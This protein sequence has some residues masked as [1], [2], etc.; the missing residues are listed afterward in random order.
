M[1]TRIQAFL[2]PRHTPD[3]LPY[4]AH[5]PL[6]VSILS[7]ILY[8]IIVTDWDIHQSIPCVR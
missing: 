6:E 2:P 1:Y 4:T 5:L 8:A 3:E 7:P